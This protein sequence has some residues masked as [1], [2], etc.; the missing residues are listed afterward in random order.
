M[1]FL[2][3]RSSVFLSG[4]SSVPVSSPPHR[5]RT[6]VA[7]PVKFQL[8]R[9]A[10][11]FRRRATPAAGAP[12]GPPTG[13]RSNRQLLPPVWSYR[14]TPFPPPRGPTTPPAPCALR[15]HPTTHPTAKPRLVIRSRWPSSCAGSTRPCAAPRRPRLSCTCTTPPF[16]SS[17]PTARPRRL[18]AHLPNPH[19]SRH[20]SPRSSSEHPSPP[21][22]L[23]DLPQ[24]PTITHYPPRAPPQPPPQRRR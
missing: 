10:R 14:F 3:S 2:G 6:L 20:R 19:P 24:V 22:R 16:H 23:P 8:T 15:V 17:T 12:G 18:D 5:H 9:A 21:P 4:G 1:I 7:L 11:A 13:S